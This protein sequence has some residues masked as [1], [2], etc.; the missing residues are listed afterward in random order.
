[1]TPST[2][3]S[4]RDSPSCCR[5]CG[6]FRLLLLRFGEVLLAVFERFGFKLLLQLQH[7]FRLSLVRHAERLFETRR[8]TGR[9]S[10]RGG[11]MRFARQQ[12][13]SRRTVRFP[14]DSSSAWQTMR[15]WF[16]INLMHWTPTNVL[17]EA[18]DLDDFQTIPARTCNRQGEHS[19]R[20]RIS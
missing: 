15:L 2:L 3:V 19:H 10:R 6:R 12:S 13:D 9:A 18:H 17:H 1:M 16:Q 4:C 5:G 7:G 11:A 14:C 8:N 20:K